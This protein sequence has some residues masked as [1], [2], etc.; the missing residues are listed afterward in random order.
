MYICTHI[1]CHTV[2]TM[3]CGE[4][5]MIGLVFAW[6]PRVVSLFESTKM[7]RSTGWAKKALRLLL[8]VACVACFGLQAY[9]CLYKFFGKKTTVGNWLEMVE[10]LVLPTV[11]ICPGKRKNAP[12][13]QDHYGNETLQDAQGLQV[14]SLFTHHHSFIHSSIH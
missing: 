2:M 8:L 13:L 11:A 1:S 10:G 14:A 7:I 3:Q 5:L 12:S 6:Q 9:E 4:W